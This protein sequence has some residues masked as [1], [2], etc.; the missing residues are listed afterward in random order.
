M[1]NAP[2]GAEPALRAVTETVI[3]PPA[4]TVAGPATAVICRSAKS[5]IST[6]RAVTLL[7]SSASVT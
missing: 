6:A 2:T 7:P 3:D 1:V 5:P 4:R